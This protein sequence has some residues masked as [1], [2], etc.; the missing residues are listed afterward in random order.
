MISFVWKLPMG[1]DFEINVYVELIWLEQLPTR[2]RSYRSL[3]QSTLPN[4]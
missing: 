3:L 4:L 1:M 2:F